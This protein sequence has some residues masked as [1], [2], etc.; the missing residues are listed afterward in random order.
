MK[1][2]KN[3]KLWQYRLLTLL[4]ITLLLTCSFYTS[5][6]AFRLKET[7]KQQEVQQKIPSL[8][9]GMYIIVAAFKIAENATQYA[10]SIKI[11]GKTPGV[12]RYDAN[13]LYYVYAH[14]TPD[15]LEYA[16]A[17]RGELRKTTQFYDAW[18]L[19]VGLKLSELIQEEEAPDVVTINQPVERKIEDIVPEKPKQEEFIPPPPV[20]QEPNQ[21]SFR[22]KAINATTLDEVQGDITIID[23]DRNKSMKSVS[24]NQTH[25]LEAPTTQSKEIIALC[26]I[27]GFAKE[28]VKFKIDDPMSSPDKNAM[29]ESGGITTV[30]FNLARHN[31]GKVLTMYNVYFYNNAAIMK[32]E[33]KFELASLYNMLKENENLKIKIHGHTNGNTS[34]KIIKLR[35]DDDDFFEITSNNIEGVGSAK[36]LSKERALTIS[37]WLVD[38]GID[39]NRMEIKGWGGKKMIYKKTDPMAGKNVRVEIELLDG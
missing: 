25:Q 32:P 26:D 20:K 19:Y 15:D 5:T 27:F 37:R 38:Q 2:M 17:R 33:S 8:E 6:A 11:K 12:G 1:C 39:G 18:I 28:Q 30:T 10:K 7:L 13:G 31:V 29:V 14:S 9:K 16:R 3:L 24:T 34:G 4:T 22:F 36:E 35:K 21:Y 23:A